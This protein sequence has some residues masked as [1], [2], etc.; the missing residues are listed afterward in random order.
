MSRGADPHPLQHRRAR[1]RR[2]RHRARRGPGGL[3]GRS[4][5]ARVVAETRPL[6][7]GARLTAWELER[8]GIPYTLIADVAA[9]TLMASGRVTHVVVGADRIAA[10]GDVVS[11]SVTYGLAILGREHGSC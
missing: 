8:E 7:Q 9:A 5:G 1:D 2:L 11:R 10:N 4:H 3:R 6:L